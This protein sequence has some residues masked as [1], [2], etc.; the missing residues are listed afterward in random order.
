MTFSFWRSSYAITPAS[1][2]PCPDRSRHKPAALILRRAAV[3]DSLG[4]GARCSWTG[5]QALRHDAGIEIA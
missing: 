3:P 1:A 2:S 4:S 5:A